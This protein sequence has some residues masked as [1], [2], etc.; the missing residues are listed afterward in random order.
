MIIPT[1]MAIWIGQLFYGIVSVIAALSDIDKSVYY[2]T[3]NF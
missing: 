1:L 3:V 2:E